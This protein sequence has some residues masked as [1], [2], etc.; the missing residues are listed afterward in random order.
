[1]SRSRSS[2][3]SWSTSSRPG[4]GRSGCSGSSMPTCARSS[5]YGRPRCTT[6]HRPATTRWWSPST[7]PSSVP[8]NRSRPPSS[9]RGRRARSGAP[10]PTVGEHTD[11][12]L[13]TAAGWP[14]PDPPTRRRRS[15]ITRPLLDGVR[16]LDLGAY[17]AGP[18]S[19]RLLADLGAEVVKVEPLAGDPLRG[20][21]R[22]FF[23]AQAGK[24]AM[25]A[26]L[27]DPA[28]APCH[29]GDAPAGRRRPPQPATGRGR[30]TG[31]R[32]RIRPPGQSR[33]RVPARAGVGFD[34]SVRDA[35][36]L[37]ADALRLR[38]A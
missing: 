4:R 25:A 27:K 36:E 8:W 17:Y 15:P 10:A 5:T 23:S 22:P 37:R 35:P 19:S 24:R 7:I 20:I 26:N 34:G 33:R 21:E 18:Y 28:L 2:S 3:S 38:R 9:S 1:M 16:I 13:A 14:R 11:A 30:T 6:R 12:V 32:R 31:S 29:R